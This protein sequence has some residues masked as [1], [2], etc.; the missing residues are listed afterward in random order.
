LCFA[1]QI[2]LN[3]QKIIR[4]NSVFVWNPGVNL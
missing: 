2:W 1:N 3:I 4:D